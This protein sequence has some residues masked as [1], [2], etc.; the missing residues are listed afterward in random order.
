[1]MGCVREG[2][3][4]SRG[5]VGASGAAAGE[6]GAGGGEAPAAGGASEQLSD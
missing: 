5:A 1:M 6:A 4:D 2:G 3:A